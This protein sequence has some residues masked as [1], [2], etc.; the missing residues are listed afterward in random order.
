[1]IETLWPAGCVLVALAL[2]GLVVRGTGRDT[3]HPRQERDTYRPA[4]PTTCAVDDEHETLKIQH[5]RRGE[6][7][8]ELWQALD[9]EPGTGRDLVESV[10]NLTTDKTAEPRP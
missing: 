7:I 3:A 6:L 10:R 2:V 9:R 5:R 1:M 8:A 4:A